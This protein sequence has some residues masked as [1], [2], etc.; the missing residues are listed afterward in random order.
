M[1]TQVTPPPNGL[2]EETVDPHPPVT[3]RCISIRLASDS[4]RELPYAAGRCSQPVKRSKDPNLT[5]RGKNV[6][7]V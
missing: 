5:K 3:R 4:L 1:R 2:V 6:A 7:A